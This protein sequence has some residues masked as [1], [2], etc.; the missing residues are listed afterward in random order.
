MERR[1]TSMIK[2]P[3]HLYSLLLNDLR[4]AHYSIIK[5]KITDHGRIRTELGSILDKHIQPDHPH[6]RKGNL[7]VN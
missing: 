6:L 3:P 1:Q 5:H 2:I 7:D 4:E